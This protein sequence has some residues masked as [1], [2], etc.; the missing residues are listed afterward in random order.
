MKPDSP[1]LGD[2]SA[3]E[4]QQLK[5]IG[6]GSSTFWHRVRFEL[7]GNVVSRHRATG[8]LDLGAGSGQLGDWT[9]DRLPTVAYRYRETSAP[10]ADALR[11]RFGADLEHIEGS[12]VPA[13]MVVA[14]LDVLEHIEDD[15]G[16]LR[17]LHESME[18]GGR[19][20]IT[21]PAIQWLF[22]PWDTDLGHHRRYTRRSL[23]TVVQSS[24]FVVES[25]SYLFPELLPIVLLRKLRNSGG[26]T[27]DFPRLPRWVDRAGE[28]LSSSTT[29]LRR[30]WPAGTSVVC[31]AR[32]GW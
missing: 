3:L 9:R 26:G 1:D 6:D 24:G 16:A 11:R 29:K 2:V 10:L 8:V 18:P 17:T 20:V 5:V 19:L 32:R 31:V 4:R 12:D 13:S 22:S 25:T 27:A 28:V 15:V 7:V 21:V 14:M 23:Q 30:L